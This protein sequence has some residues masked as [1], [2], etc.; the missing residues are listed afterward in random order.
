MIRPAFDSARLST[1][2]AAVLLAATLLAGGLAACAPAED[3]TAT[4]DAETEGAAA[5]APPTPDD[6]PNGLLVAL[7]VLGQTDD[8]R[9]QP[10][11][12]RLGILTR[13]GGEWTYSTLVDEDSNVFHKAMV[14][15]PPGDEA[16]PGILTLGGSEAKVALWRAADDADG[17]QETVLWQEDFGGKFS[18]MRD[19]EIG[20]LLGTGEPALAVATHDQGIVAVVEGAEDGWKVTEL[21]RKEDTFVHEIEIGDL[22]ADGVL[23]IYATPSARNQLDG[24]PQPGEVTRYVPR[25]GG[26]REVVAPLGDRHAKEILVA[27][28]DGDGKDELYVA[29]EAVSGGDVEIRRYD[30][31]DLAAERPEGELGG[32]RIT[33]LPDQLTRFLTVGDADGD[34]DLEM[35]AAAKSS[36]LWLLEPPSSTGDEGW[37]RQNV[38]RDSGGFEHAAL[39]ADLDGDGKDELYV[40]SD[41][42]DEI[43]R[44]VWVDGEAVRETIHAWDDGLSRFTWN[45]M[46]VPVELL[47]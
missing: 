31:D 16:E 8:G 43:R 9:P 18:R 37:S 25:T 14:F 38:D 5:Q 26:E 24:E 42:H 15:D 22:D 20:D 23:E 13:E 35:V 12:A 47:P 11:P 41:D 45:L 4:G 2:L 19:G 30:A 1:A 33:T 6:L 40:S 10:L 29:I 44:Y 34:G 39:F 46:P 28:V 21:D 36:G 27:D 32:T 3:S 17:W 7:A